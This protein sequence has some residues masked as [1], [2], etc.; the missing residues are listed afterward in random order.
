MIK[1]FICHASEDHGFLDW[2]K[3]NL[4]RENIGL[5][6]FIDDGSVFVG[7]DAQKMIDEVKKSIIFIPILSKYSVHK[8]FIINETKTA[9]NNKTTHV[10][11]IKFKCGDQDIP[12]CIKIKFVSH[13]KVQG[14]IYED[15]SNEKEWGTYYENLRKAILNKIIELGLLKETDREFFQDC[16]HLDLIMKRDEPTTF[17][18]KTIVDIYLK[19]IEYQRYFFSRLENPKWL[20]YLKYYGFLNSNPKPVTTDSSSTC[21]TIPF[22]WVLIYLER[23]SQQ[24]S[25]KEN[26]H[27]VDELIQIIH[28]V[29]NCRNNKDEKID[30]YHTWYSFIK[31]FGNLPSEKIGLDDL[32]LI[33][34]WLDSKFDNLL[35]THE[36]TKGLLPKFLN[37][38]KSKDWKK[39]E[40]VVEMITELKKV[41]P[42][43]ERAIIDKLSNRE[44]EKEKAVLANV[45]E[46]RKLFEKYARLLGERCSK[47]LIYSLI[48]K[49][50]ELIVK[51]DEFSYV[52]L[53][54]FDKLKEEDYHYSSYPS[55]LLLIF[56]LTKMLLEKADKNTKETKEI[57]SRLSKDE[58]KIL[59]RLCLF[60]IDK[61]Y[62]N[63]K[64]IFWSFIKP[65]YFGESN[66]RD[67]LASLLK[68]HFVKFDEG[69]K[70]II[71]EYIKNNVGEDIREDIEEREK[72][73]ILIKQEWL[74]LLINKSCLE[75]DTLY[76]EYK[77]N[78]LRD[79]EF[80]PRGLIKEVDLKQFTPISVEDL[81]GKSNEEIVR[82]LNKFVSSSSPIDEHLLED[83]FKEAVRRD[84][85]RFIENLKAFLY[86]K[87]QYSR[88]IVYAFSDLW[89]EKKI[90]DWGKILDFCLKKIK[91]GGFWEDDSIDKTRY[92][93]STVSAIS[94]L[95]EGGIRDDAW[96]FSQEYLPLAEKII[97]EI[98][99]NQKSGLTETK[100]AYGK[101]INT[102]KGRT[103]ESLI[104]YALRYARI[105]FNKPED[106]D[107]P[108]W[109]TEEVKDAF[110]KALTKKDDSFEF[111]V[112]MGRYL[113]NLFYLDRELFINEINKIFPKD[114]SNHWNVAM[115]GY[116]WSRRVYDDL[117]KVLR[118]YNHYLKGLQE[119]FGDKYLREMLIQ[120][121]CI[122]YLRDTEILSGED[123]LFAK[124]LDEWKQ[125]DICEI[126]SFFWG[127]KKGETDKNIRKHI[128]DFWSFSYN[129]LKNKTISE[130]DKKILSDI[131]LLA[132]FLENLDAEKKKWLLQSI[133]WV[134]INHHSSF[135]MEYLD[136]FTDENS[137]EVGEI[138]IRM[139]KSDVTPTYD[140]KHIISIIEKLF[141]KKEKAA[142]DTVTNIYC[143]KLSS[144]SLFNKMRD[145]CERNRSLVITQ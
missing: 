15:F 144:G 28:S 141:S 121:I 64:D 6:I 138:F 77:K 36:I 95:I 13:D 39:A 145:L 133:P 82:F 24:T 48:N 115:Q 140:E 16:E 116:L 29:T 53:E 137:K 18:I 17:E 125:E 119:E 34:K 32:G 65:E 107:K 70:N 139:L 126:I 54:S 93:D 7:D 78:S 47:D 103:I 129:K 12:E 50:K 122:G 63:F 33:K 19:K 25:K 37:S 2:L 75:A 111:S 73:K 92:R 3:V 45:F 142:V 83:V 79:V 127:L 42:S 84:P 66:L 112:L 88:I 8:E 56:G 109:S 52:W 27:Y 114:N 26:E 69:Q 62:E 86:L 85:E 4:E 1:T 67:E 102:A 10:F 91:G 113:P 14:K 71:I 96:A 134:E 58:F 80:C 61:N 105:N 117:Y 5:D 68:N 100:D 49:I 108:K 131:N 21:F 41:D 123:S 90:I 132:T 110:L 22:W 81:L 135:L 128:L 20:K 72:W 97:L 44:P 51:N 38:N 120:H 46:L 43:S 9:L 11:P 106:K 87:L 89:K 60:I 31:I 74:A 101:T 104:N 23:V 99:K 98:L 59:N 57:L 40:K 55:A 35:V 124:I 130:D 143:S 136:M 30:N 118:E 94:F 76:E